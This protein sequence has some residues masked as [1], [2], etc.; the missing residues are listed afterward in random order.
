MEETNLENWLKDIAIDGK[1]AILM[2]DKKVLYF[3]N[4]FEKL[5]FKLDF[6]LKNY[7]DKGS[8]VY[9]LGHIDYDTL[10]LF[11]ET[12]L[13]KDIDNYANKNNIKI[14]PIRL[15]FINDVK[16]EIIIADYLKDFPN[17]LKERYLK[18]IFDLKDDDIILGYEYDKDGFIKSIDIGKQL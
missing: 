7:N 2:F 4:D 5:L 6:W 8:A 12:F 16:L 15:H 1:E 10:I 17:D 3:D 13:L 18:K 9:D 11:V 14:S